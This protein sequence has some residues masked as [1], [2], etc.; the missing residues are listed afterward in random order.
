M[1]NMDYLVTIDGIDNFIE[2]HSVENV[3]DGV[4]ERLYA[5]RKKLGLTQQD[6]ADATGIKRPNIARLEAKKGG[7]SLET[8]VRY[9]DAL[10]MKLNISLEKKEH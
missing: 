7:A 5:Y 9:A 3:T 6:I 4:V 10:G 8:L 2:K 1:E